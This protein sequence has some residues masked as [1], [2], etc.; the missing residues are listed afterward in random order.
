MEKILIYVWFLNLG[1]AQSNED[2]LHQ[3]EAEFN[4]LQTKIA[5]LENA[6][7]EAQNLYE[8]LSS[9]LNE[10]TMSNQAIEASIFEAQQINENLTKNLVII[11]NSNQD[12]NTSNETTEN[13]QALKLVQEQNSM[14]EYNITE[15]K[16][17]N[18]QLQTNLNEW[19]M[20]NSTLE[21][22]I[23][24]VQ[25][26]NQKLISDLN[27]LQAS[28]GQLESQINDMQMAKSSPN[29]TEADET[30]ANLNSLMQELESQSKL[31]ENNRL[32]LYELNER[33][34]SKEKELNTLNLEHQ[35]LLLNKQDTVQQNLNAL[36]SQIESL[37]KQNDS[38][39]S[40][41]R[42]YEKK[43]DIYENLIK[44]FKLLADKQESEKKASLEKQEVLL[45]MKNNLI[46]RLESD[47]LKQTEKASKIN[48]DW[49]F[50]ADFEDYEEKYHN[51]LKELDTLNEQI[52]QITAENTKLKAERENM[53]KLAMRQGEDFGSKKAELEA[54]VLEYQ[55][56]NEALANNLSKWKAA[57]E[58]IEGEILIQQSM[59]NSLMQ[60]MSEWKEVNLKVE[61]SLIEK[62]QKGEY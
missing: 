28:G 48:N 57:N 15:A 54:N 62:K 31:I 21:A 38:F 60:N 6:I 22:S 17:L 12:T 42:A 29:S 46:A 55:K 1:S 36:E 33:L 43:C 19:N 2:Q 37:N 3:K 44:R 39:I 41:I 49:G 52:N 10:W 20:A 40:E 7:L 56:T 18:F 4:D 24:S 11:Q 58:R 9:N 16:E 32:E 50:D 51:S 13:N 35:T 30:H 26:L 27:E 25:E 45:Q 5:P 61:A 47:L 8:S 14:L 53:P 59:N 34:L 23:I